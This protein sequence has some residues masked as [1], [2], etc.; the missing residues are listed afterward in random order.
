MVKSIF[1]FAFCALFTL[2][3]S[4]QAARPSDDTSREAALIQQLTTRMR[5]ENDGTGVREVTSAVLMQSQA[6]VQQY[7][8]LVFGYSSAT[9][10]LEVTYVRVR[11]P[12]GQVVET[13][14]ANA[15][16]FA[17]EVLQSAKMYGDYRERH[18]TVVGLRPGD[19]LESRSTT[20]IT[21]PLAAGEFWYEY[22]FPRHTAVT[23]VRLEIDIPKARELKLKSPAR[24]YSTTEAGDRRTYSW[25]VENITPNR[26]END[27]T[28]EEPEESDDEGPDVQLTTFKDWSQVA[29][30][31]A[32]LQGE[33][34]VVDDAIQ[35]KAAELTKGA[36]TPQ[37]KAQRLYDY[38]ARDIRYVSLSFGV[39]RFQRHA[40]PE[41][42]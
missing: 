41:V 26:K 4:S 3:G 18:V 20:H 37:E 15:Q 14:A 31:Y 30:W 9:E 29:H 38:V 2:P 12:G 24:K 33:R 17:P 23:Q 42:M 34:V 6:G 32:K 16:D 28:D 40:A 8:Q 5:Y 39:G 25:V 11:K 1:V 36:A 19:V 21:T 22:R 27:D 35:K 13:P 7:G 10:Q